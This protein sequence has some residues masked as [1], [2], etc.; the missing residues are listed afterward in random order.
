MNSWTKVIIGIWAYVIIQTILFAFIFIQMS[1][2][3]EQLSTQIWNAQQQLSNQ[4][5]E[6]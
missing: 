3:S 6:E 1:R 2:Y 4:I 5:A